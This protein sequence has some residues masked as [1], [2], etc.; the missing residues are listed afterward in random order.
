MALRFSPCGPTIKENK[1]ARKQLLWSTAIGLGLLAGHAF[2]GQLADISLY[3]RSEGRNLPVYWHEGKAYVVGKPGNEYQ[4]I[5]ANRTD[6]DVLAVLSV[7]GVNGITGQTAAAEQSG[8]VLNRWESMDIKGWR[9]NLSRTAAF[10]FTQLAD[11]YA[12]RTGR[13]ANVGVIGVALFRRKEHEAY[14]A[15]P[16]STQREPQAAESAAAPPAADGAR[17]DSA[18]AAP[19]KREKSLGTGHGRNEASPAEYTSFER[20]TSTPEE[21]ITIYYDSHRNLLAR[22]VIQA[23]PGREPQ[24]F[25]AGFVPDP[26]RRW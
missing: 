22:G 15:P 17:S 1:V 16:H 13:P 11:S 4:I 5:V 10:Y 25:P 24:P 8:Y 14:L 6:S 19:Q 12:A 20:A 21:V 18:Q 23:P 2:A 7:D 26:P 9:K 3:D